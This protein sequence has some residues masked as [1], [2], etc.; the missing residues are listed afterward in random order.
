MSDPNDFTELPGLGVRVDNVEYRPDL[1]TPPDHPHCFDYFITITN[2]SESTVTLGGRK[3]L[4]TNSRGEMQVLEG[5]GIV[6]QTPRLEPGAFFQYNSRHLLDT[7][8]GVA[9]GA[10]F[11]LDQSN[12]RIMTRIPRFHMRVPPQ[13]PSGS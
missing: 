11:G 4:V 3:W 12:R 7:E 10:Y 8:E 6:G 13:K 5:D 1:E 9:E 2:Q